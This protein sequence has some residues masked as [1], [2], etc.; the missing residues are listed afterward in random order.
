VS[1]TYS[2]EDRDE[3]ARLVTAARDVLPTADAPAIVLRAM[4]ALVAIVDSRHSPD[5]VV[6]VA[7]LL[8]AAGLDQ[9]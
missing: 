1:L 5:G 9:A 8:K 7:S 4:R 2:V 3:L 6:T